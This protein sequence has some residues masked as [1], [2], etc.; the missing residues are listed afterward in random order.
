MGRMLNQTGQIGQA[1]L[2]AAPHGEFAV[3]R[4]AKQGGQDLSRAVGALEL[5]LG[6]G[7]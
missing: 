6:G 3:L 7:V 1:E 2:S 4:L 5:A